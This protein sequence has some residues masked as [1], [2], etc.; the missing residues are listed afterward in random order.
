MSKTLFKDRLLASTMIAGMAVFATPALAQDQG[1]A[2]PTETPGVVPQAAV[3]EEETSTG[4]IVVTGTLIQNP[5]LVA[6]SPVAVIGEDELQLQQVNNV[7]EVLR[8]LPGASA[9]LGS[10]VNNGSVGS[11]RVDLRSLG[12]TSRSP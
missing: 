11:A 5:N 6:S 2:D 1:Q 12:A 9:N 10:N 4:E 3:A 8:E 7:E